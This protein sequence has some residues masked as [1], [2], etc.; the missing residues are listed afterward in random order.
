MDNNITNWEFNEFGDNEPMTAKE[1]KEK[2]KEVKG[3]IIK[4]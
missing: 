4:Q 3:V 2:L 1:L